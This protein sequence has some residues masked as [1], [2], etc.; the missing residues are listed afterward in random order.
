M[1]VAEVAE[2]IAVDRNNQTF[3]TENRML[4]IFSVLNI[5]SSL[6][7]L[8]ER[9][10]TL[11]NGQTEETRKL[12]LAHYSVK[13]YLVSRRIQTSQAKKFAI[14]ETE[15][16]EYMGEACLI[17]LLHFNRSDSIYT[18]VWVDYPFLRY[19]AESWYGHRKV[20]LNASP[21]IMD[22]STAL[23][24]IKAGSQFI[25]WLRLHDPEHPWSGVDLRR[26]IETFTARL[27]YPS[28]L[29]I[30]EVVER[31]L[32]AGADVNAA[33]ATAD[34]G[35]TALQAASESG[36]LEVVERLLAAG[37]DVNAAA[38]YYD[39]NGRT[40]LQAASGGGH[41]EVVERLLAAGADVNA[42][43]AGDF[44]GTALQAASKSGHLEVV[45]RLLAAGADAN[46]AAIR[47]G[48]TALRAASVHGH[49]E[50]VERLRKSISA[51]S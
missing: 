45:E 49:L 15:A 13:E 18:D 34:F 19:A 16:H 14:K 7:T 37:A 43:P 32:A 50:V 6:V 35:R 10:A 29:G 44:G 31:L 20:I 17:Y 51:G 8:S 47:H 23:F 27:Y 42:A 5:C 46:A 36:H 40:A 30:L 4:D 48:W 26:R 22:L 41:L 25:N 21:K 38:A 11:K 39:Y 3:D 9:K 2:A 12:R 28:L 24:D 33:A 1:N